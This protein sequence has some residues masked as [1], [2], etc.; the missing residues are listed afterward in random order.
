[1]CRTRWL[2]VNVTLLVCA[3][4]VLGAPLTTAF[5]YQGQLKSDGSPANGPHDMRFRL[6]DAAI[7][8][9]ADGISW[10]AIRPGADGVQRARASVLFGSFVRGESNVEL[11]E[12]I[13][14]LEAA[15]LKASFAQGDK[16]K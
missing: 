10:N 12:R 7:A 14:R 8:K 15:L 9:S 3:G 11:R 16:G 5:T 2:A 6:F 1:M 13:A 4:T